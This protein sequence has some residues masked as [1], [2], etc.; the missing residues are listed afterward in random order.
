[1]SYPPEFE[2]YTITKLET[3]DN[4]AKIARELI[5]VFDLDTKEDLVRRQV[6]RIAQKH[7]IAQGKKPIKRLFFDIET[8]FVQGWFWRTG[9]KQRV[10]VW[11][12]KVPKKIICI[13][14]KWQHEEK[15]R[16]FKWDKNQDDKALLQKFIQVLGDAD[17][18]IGHN[19][20]KFDIKE[21][22]TRCIKQDVLMFPTYR[23]LDT[24]K[25][26]KRFFS[27]ESN[28]LDFIARELKVGRKIET[29]KTLWERIIYHKCP[30]ALKEMVT[31]CN[32]DVLLNE[33]VFTAMMPYIDHNTN[34]AV[35]KGKDKWHCPECSGGNVV[36]SH[37]DTT[38]M[39]YVKRHM[40]CND[41]RKFFK[42]SNKTYLRYLKGRKLDLTG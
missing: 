23:T 5:E 24:Y 25:K 37:T 14:Y 28:S 13:S 9:W 21:I 41:C 40:K 15:V 38:P 7:N 42:V 1:M 34:F 31:Y 2:E 32:G 30:K 6:S 26:A 36:L 10:G 19:I 39:G 3:S 33:D 22:R 18:A 11:Q 35:L 16:N 29:D 4:R 27:F 12:I 20:D 17:E 8:S